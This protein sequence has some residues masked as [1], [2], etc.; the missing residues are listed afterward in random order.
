M[1]KLQSI[2]FRSTLAIVT[3]LAVLAGSVRAAYAGNGAITWKNLTNTY[4]AVGTCSDPDGLYQVTTVS[5]GV[6]N[7][8]ENENGYKFNWHDAGTFFL[9]PIDANS[10]VTYSG[11]YSEQF[12]DHLNKG[13]SMIKHTFTNVGRGSDGTHEV[14]HITFRLVL[15]P[16]GLVREVDNFQWICN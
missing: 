6:V 5:N 12:Q 13:S 7:L 1:K 8:V 2:L 16:D 11:R 9:E 10:S 4:E 15:T 14:F 3:T